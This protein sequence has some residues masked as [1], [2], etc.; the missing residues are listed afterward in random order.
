V[1]HVGRVAAYICGPQRVI[2]AR[3]R[4]K[5]RYDQEWPV[6]TTGP[7]NENYSRVRRV[8]ISLLQV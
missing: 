5:G 4:R 6:A 8:K 3:T 7:E 2:L 1:N